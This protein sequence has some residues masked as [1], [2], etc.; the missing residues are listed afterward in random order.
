MVEML[1]VL[2]TNY[3]GLG[4]LRLLTSKVPSD[5]TFVNYPT[6]SRFQPPVG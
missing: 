6:F 4:S 2:C 1:E 5:L 3:V